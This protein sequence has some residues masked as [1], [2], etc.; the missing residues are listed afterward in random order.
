MFPPLPLGPGPPPITWLVQYRPSPPAHSPAGHSLACLSGAS[1]LSVWLRPA[2]S[3][4][5]GSLR[6]A[7]A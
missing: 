4:P 2:G 5:H 1:P 3:P 7:T 6:D